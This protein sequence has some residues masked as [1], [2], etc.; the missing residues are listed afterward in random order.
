MDAHF[1][2]NDLPKDTW[3]ISR[4]IND[5]LLNLS[6]Y[7]I[8]CFFYQLLMNILNIIDTNVIIAERELVEIPLK[9]RFLH[10]LTEKYFKIFPKFSEYGVILEA[11]PVN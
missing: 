5:W 2:V 10:V 4:T 9:S 6:L 7:A 1:V 3:T 8:L 11:F